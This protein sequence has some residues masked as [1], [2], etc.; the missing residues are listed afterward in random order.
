MR[1]KIGKNNLYDLWLMYSPVFAE[2]EGLILWHFHVGASLADI[3]YRQ[4]LRG[5]NL[6][7]DVC[8]HEILQL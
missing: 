7:Q 5:L 1:Y 8:L 6:N 4:L 2:S 3:S